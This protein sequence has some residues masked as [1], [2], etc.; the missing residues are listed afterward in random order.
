MDK[1]RCLQN[2]TG[3]SPMADTVDYYPPTPAHVPSNLTRST[4]SYR[5]RVLVVLLSLFL[6]LALYLALVLG[7]AYLC[8]YSFAQLGTQQPT[9]T[10]TTKG[11]VQYQYQSA[12]RR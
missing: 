12:P 11:R 2:S 10:V 6:F 3:A 5:A 7:S 4:G 1:L 8:Y 9:T